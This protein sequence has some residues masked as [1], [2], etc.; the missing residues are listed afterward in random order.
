MEAEHQLKLKSSE[1]RSGFDRRK[2]NVADYNG[3]ERRIILDRRTEIQRR[4][5]NRFRPKALTFIRLRSESEEDMGQLLDIS[6][7]G[8]SL[9]YVDYAEKALDY[10][11]LEIL[12]SGDEFTIGRIPF[13]TVSSDIKLTFSPYFRPL[14][15]IEL[16]RHGVKF[17]ELT[18]D[19]LSKLDYFLKNCT[20]GEA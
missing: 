15:P 11:E 6:K 2:F 18:P 5:H 1:R 17:E 13:Q 20:L 4:K 8:L 14:Y 9:R 12:L 19:Q 7:A 16:R 10:S 3:L